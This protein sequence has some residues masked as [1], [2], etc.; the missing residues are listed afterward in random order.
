MSGPITYFL[1]LFS[2]FAQAQRIINL[3]ASLVQ[4]QGTS[5]QVLIRFSLT[6]G[7]ACPGYEIQHSLDSVNYLQIYNYAGICGDSGFEESFSFTHSNPMFNQVNYYRVVIPGF[8]T[9][10]VV[11][12]F[13]S[14][15]VLAANILPYPNPVVNENTLYLKFFNFEGPEL[16][17]FVFNQNGVREKTLYLKNNSGL[18]EFDIGILRNGL[19]IIWLTDGNILM[20]S[21]FIVKRP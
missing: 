9:S 10:R 1:I 3:N 12:V 19:Y 16:E 4:A 14:E 5:P 13:V 15:N 17:G 8:E 20:R 7:Q 6:A 2:F 21:K 11:S 18:A